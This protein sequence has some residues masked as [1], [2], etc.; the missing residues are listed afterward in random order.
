MS[1]ILQL[2]SAISGVLSAIR[3]N[4]Y[5]LFAAGKEVKKTRQNIFFQFL[6]LN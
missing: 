2:Q 4:F 5:Y 1:Q 6:V 3:S